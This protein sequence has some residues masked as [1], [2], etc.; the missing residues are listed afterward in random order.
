[1]SK[2]FLLVF[3][4]QINHYKFFI[5]IAIILLLANLLIGAMNPYL[6]IDYFNSKF[7]LSIG[8]TLPVIAS[9]LCCTVCQTLVKK[10]W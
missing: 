1:M 2:L 8:G 4:F 7:A 5:L 10:I 6:Y 3:F 9:F